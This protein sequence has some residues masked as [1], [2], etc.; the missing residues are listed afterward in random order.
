DDLVTLYHGDALEVTEWLSANVL[1]TDPPYG[2]SWDG[3]AGTLK[4]GKF[5]RRESNLIH[6]DN[7]LE[8]RDKILLLWADKPAIIFGTWRMPKPEKTQHRLIWHKKG[9]APGPA[10]APFMIQDEEIYILGN[11]FISTS[12]PMRSVITTHEARSIE[13]A[14]IGHPTPKPI[15]LMEMLI[16][17]LVAARNLGRKVI[18]VEIDEKYCELI[19]KRLSQQV[20]DFGSLEA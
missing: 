10:N 3:G 14:K 20:F 8:V 13:V 7:S 16:A 17:T 2:I 18:G 19:A 9:Q 4:N 15:S 12:P 6:G 5:V 1:V 11:G